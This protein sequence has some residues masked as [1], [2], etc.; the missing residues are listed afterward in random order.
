MNI[1]TLRDETK[2]K[3]LV[4]VCMVLLAKRG[5]LGNVPEL[6]IQA[7]GRFIQII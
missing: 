6:D 1:F 3:E 4:T 2:E 5:I 7:L